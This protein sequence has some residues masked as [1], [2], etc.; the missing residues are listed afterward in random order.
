MDIL[1]VYGF[2]QQ[3]HETCVT[4]PAAYSLHQQSMMYGVEV[5]GQ[6][7]FNHP[8]SPGFTAVCEL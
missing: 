2:P 8:A 7:A 1:S 3:S 5:T 6:V 4:D